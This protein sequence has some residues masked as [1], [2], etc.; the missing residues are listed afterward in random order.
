M[1]SCGRKKK[2]CS[3]ISFNYTRTVSSLK[4][5]NEDLAHYLAEAAFPAANDTSVRES[6]HFGPLFDSEIPEF[7]EGFVLS[8]EDGKKMR[9]I[10]PEGEDKA[11]EVRDY[12][13][14]RL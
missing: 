14:H 12:C 3:H 8:E 1:D 11:R 5:A 4:T 2:S 7:V 10:W 9:Q 6:N 13:I